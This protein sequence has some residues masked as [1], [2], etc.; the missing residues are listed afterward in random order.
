MLDRIGAQQGADIDIPGIGMRQDSVPAF[1]GTRLTS[2]Q[3][4]DGA[5]LDARTGFA[6]RDIVEIPQYTVEE[7]QAR[8]RQAWATGHGYAMATRITMGDWT[9]VSFAPEGASKEQ[10]QEIIDTSM[11]LARQVQRQSGGREVEIEFRFA[12]PESVTT[13]QS[14]VHVSAQSISEPTEAAQQQ[15]DSAENLAAMLREFL[16]GT[17]GSGLPGRSK[18]A[19][20]APLDITV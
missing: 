1:A 18:A 14:F 8:V 9:M 5:A 3:A 20:F 13:E 7:L 17:A 19:R 10:M 4:A 12:D 16:N 11:A 6:P 15:Q 2:R